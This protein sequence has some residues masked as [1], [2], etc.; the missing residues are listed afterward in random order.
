MKTAGTII[1]PLFF[2][3]IPAFIQAQAPTSPCKTNDAFRTFDFWIGEW[4]VYANGQLAGKSI[5]ELI[6]DSCVISENWTSASSAYKGKS[7]NYYDAQTGMWHQS[8]VDNFGGALKFEGKRTEN[9]IEFKGEAK[10]AEGKTIYQRLTFHLMEDSN[11]RQHW[12]QSGDKENWT[13]VFDGLYIPKG[14]EPP[15][16]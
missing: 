12:E 11:V 15:Q 10:D 16:E 2:L 4:D 7:Y 14:S 3:L 5:I 8:W 6:L 13:T 9:R 1:L